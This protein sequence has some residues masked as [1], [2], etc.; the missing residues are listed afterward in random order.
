[1]ATNAIGTGLQTASPV[2]MAQAASSSTSSSSNSTDTSSIATTFMTLL[3]QELQNQDPT[4]PMDS[5]QM[6]GQM[7]SLNQLGQL[8]SI[9]QTLTTQFGSTGT[10]TSTT[11]T[12]T[13]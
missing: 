11:S 12:P 8:T 7:I 10:G 5:T 2:A 9:N 4:A 6:V 13:A 3:A 1:M